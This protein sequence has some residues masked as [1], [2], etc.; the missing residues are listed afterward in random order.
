MLAVRNDQ[1]VWSWQ[2]KCSRRHL[3]YTEDG[4]TSALLRGQR[5]QR[6]GWTCRR[7]VASGDAGDRNRPAEFPVALWFL[8]VRGGRDA[9]LA[10]GT[11]AKAFA[12]ILKNAWKTA[13][14]PHQ[15]GHTSLP[16]PQRRWFYGKATAVHIAYGVATRSIR[17]C[18][19]R[20]SRGAGQ[21]RPLS[22]PWAP[23]KTGSPAPCP[24]RWRWPECDAPARYWVW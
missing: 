5:A 24:S 9:Q 14:H 17:C 15:P 7:G 6:P 2:R 20:S 11:G 3:A 21:V 10:C 8:L 23:A 4:H 12:T 19:V 13:Q 1:G 22:C 16:Q 18:S